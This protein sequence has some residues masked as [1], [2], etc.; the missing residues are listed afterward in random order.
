MSTVPVSIDRID[1]LNQLRDEL[2]VVWCALTNPHH[3]EE[4]VIPIAEHVNGLHH[5]L[6][7][8]LSSIQRPEAQA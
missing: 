6:V 7:A 8:I 3:A 2:Q 5:R 1:E 4:S